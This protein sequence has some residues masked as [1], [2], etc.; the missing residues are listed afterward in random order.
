MSI[1][2]RCRVRMALVW[3]TDGGDGMVPLVRR[4]VIRTFWTLH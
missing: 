2:S 1:W 3:D 4:A